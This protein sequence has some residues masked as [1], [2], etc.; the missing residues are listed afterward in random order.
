MIAKTYFPEYTSVDFDRIEQNLPRFSLLLSKKNIDL[1]N[2]DKFEKKVKKP[3][4]F[5]KYTQKKDKKTDK[6]L[7]TGNVER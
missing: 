1:I 7:E 6:N 3:T 5:E 4:F 2:V